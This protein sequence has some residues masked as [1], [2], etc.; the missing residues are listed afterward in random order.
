M[1][2]NNFEFQ[3]LFQE[4][5]LKHDC[6]YE[7]PPIGASFSFQYCEKFASFCQ[8]SL[9]PLSGVGVGFGGG[10]ERPLKTRLVLLYGKRMDMGSNVSTANIQNGGA[11]V[12]E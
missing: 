1:L 10:R 8:V 4:M 9:P 12:I 5:E 2:E 11:R 7:Y 3:F 6:T